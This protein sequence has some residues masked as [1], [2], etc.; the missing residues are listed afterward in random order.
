MRVA[1]VVNS[2]AGTVLKEGLDA[3]ALRRMFEAAGLP[4]EI[5]FLPEGRIDEGVRDALA[6]GVD[7][8][9]AGGGDGTIRTAAARLAGGSVPLGVLP[10]GTLNHFARDLGI[11][12]QVPDAIRLLQEG[13]VHALDVGE[14]NGEIFVNN[15]VLGLY[16]PVVKLRD[17]LRREKQRGKWLA[18]ASALLK[19]LPRHA[20]L[21][22]RIRAEGWELARKTRFVFVGNNEYAMNAFTY[23][24]P[25]RLDSGDLY[26]YI[27]H[28]ESRLGLI[29]LILLGLVR[30][31]KATDYFDC[32]A[33]P[34]F[35]IDLPQRSVLVYLDGEVRTLE[36][37]LR[38][39]TRL[40]DLRVILP[41]ESEVPAADERQS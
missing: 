22:V 19:L 13:T 36:T 23:G 14:V 7:A 37:P 40:R 29:G 17:R 10:L 38:Y 30:D 24:A 34:E 15:S 18:T 39:R 33:A 20:P 31:L 35:T 6:S 28:S 4:A 41:R 9:V 2:S 12:V 5:R 3:P 26:L 8:L 32:R 25:L 21:R 11:P 1:A 16:P 27:A